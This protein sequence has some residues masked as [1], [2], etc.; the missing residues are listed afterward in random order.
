MS[1]TIG[2]DVPG[3]ADGDSMQR[4]PLPADAGIPANLPAGAHAISADLIPAVAAML[5]R[6]VATLLRQVYSPRI[7]L[8][9]IE[10]VCQATGLGRSTIYALINESKFPKP[11][12]NLGKNLWREA[13]LIAWAEANDP[14]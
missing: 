9:D 10:Q 12:R 1:S 4:T 13:R 5:D 14:N 8:L 6:L 7:K 11:Q 3:P 2:P